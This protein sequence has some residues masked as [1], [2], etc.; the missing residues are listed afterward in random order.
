[1]DRYRVVNIFRFC[2]YSIEH[3]YQVLKDFHVGFIGATELEE[4]VGG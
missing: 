4:L 3:N 2:A 1:V